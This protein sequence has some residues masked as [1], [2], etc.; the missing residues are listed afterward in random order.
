MMISPAHSYPSAENMGFPITKHVPD[1]PQ[2]ILRPLTHH[3]REFRYSKF[4]VVVNQ[5][6][7]DGRSML[8]VI[9]D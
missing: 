9:V 6:E 1:L 5:V 8:I 7:Y 3:A 2:V 4:L